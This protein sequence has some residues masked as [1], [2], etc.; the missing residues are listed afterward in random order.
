[1]GYLKVF[2]VIERYG[3]PSFASKLPH[4]QAYDILLSYSLAF[5]IAVHVQN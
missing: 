5:P 1:M 4:A 2:C 3:T